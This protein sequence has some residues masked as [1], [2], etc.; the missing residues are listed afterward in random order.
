MDLKS[1]G[2]K[3]RTSRLKK[4]LTQ[5]N[6]AEKLDI[7]T[8]FMSRIENGAAMAGFETYCEICNILDITLDYLTEDLILPA[9][10]KRC[11]KE[12]STAIE[13]MTSNQID[14]ILTLVHDFAYYLSNNE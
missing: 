11:E 9:K 10:K 12:F 3:I 8:S 6:L 2:A 1:I 13:H 7:S 4:N 5:E 14:Y